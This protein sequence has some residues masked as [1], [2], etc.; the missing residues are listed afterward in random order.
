MAFE[1]LANVINMNLISF[2]AGQHI[3]HTTNF[4]DVNLAISQSKFPI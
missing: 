2:P 4:N 3:Q 1:L